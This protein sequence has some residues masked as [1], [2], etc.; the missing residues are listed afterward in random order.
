MREGQGQPDLFVR[1]ARFYCDHEGSLKSPA[2]WE[3][4]RCVAEHMPPELK[5]TL[6]P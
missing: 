1:H 2:G 3:Q 4:Q 6:T 5:T